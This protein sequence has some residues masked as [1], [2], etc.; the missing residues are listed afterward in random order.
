M[1]LKVLVLWLH[2][3][4]TPSPG[5]PCRLAQLDACPALD[6]DCHQE[7]YWEKRQ[8]AVA[9]GNLCQSRAHLWRRLPGRAEGRTSG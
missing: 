3:G 1:L 2:P 9:L 8:S 4:S 5:F 7:K 6:G